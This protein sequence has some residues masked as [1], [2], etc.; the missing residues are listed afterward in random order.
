MEGHFF[1]NHYFLIFVLLLLLLLL[2]L[3]LLLLLLLLPLL[4]AHLVFSCFCVAFVLLCFST[5][6]SQSLLLSCVLRV[7]DRFHCLR[8]HFLSKAF[9]KFASI[10]K[11]AV[12]LNAR[13]QKSYEG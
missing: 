9:F 2:L 5:S 12:P 6:L 13:H 11:A 4:S 7:V 1:G 10:K 3:P 8:C